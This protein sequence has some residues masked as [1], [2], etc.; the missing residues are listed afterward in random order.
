MRVNIIGKHTRKYQ[1]WFDE[2]NARIRI[3]IDVRSKAI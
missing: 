2:N 3:L 1:I